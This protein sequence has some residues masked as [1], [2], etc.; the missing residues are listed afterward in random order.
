[1]NGICVVLSIS[2]HDFSDISKIALVPCDG[3][4]NAGGAVLAELSHP[5]LQS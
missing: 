4:D 3:N 5:V 2:L 1:M